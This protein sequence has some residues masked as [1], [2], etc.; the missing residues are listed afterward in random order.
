MR[1]WPL[2][3]ALI[4]GP[5]W[6][7]EGLFVAR[8]GGGPVTQPAQQNVGGALNLSVDLGLSPHL[9]VSAGA[10]LIADP[11]HTS[12]G[13]GLGLKALL[14][15]ARWRRSYLRLTPELL[16]AWP[17]RSSVVP[18]LR[19]QAALGYEELV[20]WGLGLN[21]E[22]FAALP[23]G[24]QNAALRVGELGVTAGLFMEF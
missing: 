22:L 23:L 3:A 8:L 6:A 9:G 16:L 2:I 5:A 17:P 24:L 19:L 13:L 15:E 7:E 18:D 21:L 10:L 11:A 12:L 20:F 14:W 4:A 1:S